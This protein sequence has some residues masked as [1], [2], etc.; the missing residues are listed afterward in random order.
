MIAF[1]DNSNDLEMLQYVGEGIAVENAAPHVKAV[2]DT[3][4]G[5]NEDGAV[6][7]YIEVKLDQLE[8]ATE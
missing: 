4:I 8:S 3:V 5:T 1:G 6:L 2:A 7:K